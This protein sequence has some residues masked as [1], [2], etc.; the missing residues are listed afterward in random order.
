MKIFY[1]LKGQGFYP[2]EMFDLYKDAGSL[3]DDLVEISQKDYDAFF[4]PPEGYG[5]VFDDKG[6]RVEKLPE[7]DSASIAENERQLRLAEI[8]PATSTLQTKL[9]MGRKLTNAETSRL[10]AWMDY[11]DALNGLDLSSAPHITWPEKP[12]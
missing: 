6:P 5:A 1:S 4:N 12:Q 3:P 8:G 9:L 7:V 11:S 10:N 2:E